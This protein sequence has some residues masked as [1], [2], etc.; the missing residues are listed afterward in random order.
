M[1][2]TLALLFL[3]AAMGA[4]HAGVKFA[5][6]D[7]NR[8]LQ[9][10][11]L[12]AQA[13]KE[14]REKLIEYQTKLSNKQKKLE[15]LKKQIESKAISQKAK[16]EKIKEY[17][18]LESEARALQEKAQ[19]ELEDMRQR[20]ESTVYNR[21]REAAEKLAKERGYTGVMDCGV[22]IYKEPEMDITTE[23]IKII[24]EGSSK[25]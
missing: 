2:R 21:V 6:V 15:E 20:L 17:Q 7:P 4:A 16:E 24:D 23:V 9:E 1:F 19:K 11:K 25:K 13:Q 12:V 14:L 18:K 10:S 22:F 3:I 5:C 8:I